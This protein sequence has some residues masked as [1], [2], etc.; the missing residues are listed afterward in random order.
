MYMLYIT[1]MLR[2]VRT[3]DRGADSANMEAE[4]ICVRGHHLYKQTWT[5]SVNDERESSNK[6][7]YAV[8]AA[9]PRGI[10]F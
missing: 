1:Q 6:D 9:T 4:S 10:L 7:A 2:P 5:P 3:F 8:A